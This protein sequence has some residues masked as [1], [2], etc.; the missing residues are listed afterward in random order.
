MR[1][2][3]EALLGQLYNEGKPRVQSPRLRLE[4]S[5]GDQV[6]WGTRAVRCEAVHLSWLDRAA[7]PL[8]PV[9]Q[10]HSHGGCASE[11]S[12]WGRPSTRHWMS[13]QG[14]A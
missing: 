14:L 12:W 5:L 4:G 9:Y 6:R 3:H 8:L 11:A 7:P 2:P 13:Q 10:L 1:L